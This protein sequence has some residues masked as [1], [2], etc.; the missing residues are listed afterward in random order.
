MTDFDE[1][2][3]PA[4]DDALEEASGVERRKR[5]SP[6]EWIDITEIYE[7][8]DRGI[9]EIADQF[10]VTRQTLSKYFKDNKIQRGSKAKEIAARNAQIAAATAAKVAERFAEKRAEWIEETRVQGYNNLKQVATLL[11]K[12][13]VE[14]YKIP[15][16]APAT[17][18]AE[19][20]EDIKALKL[21]QSALIEN[22]NFRLEGILAASDVTDENNLPSLQISDLTD[23]DIEE[24]YN[25]IGMSTPT[26]ELNEIVNSIESDDE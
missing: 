16:G 6:R 25:S 8:G 7:L 9:K 26:E 20:M 15:A 12:R 1:E 22:F 14:I 13:I 23:E 24:H 18:P 10:G 11:N 3:I 17:G 2:D 19:A 5:L 4:E 21:Y